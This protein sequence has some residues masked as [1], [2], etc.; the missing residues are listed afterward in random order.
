MNSFQ[1]DIL[2]I[3]PL[4]GWAMNH[5]QS[6]GIVQYPRFPYLF[7]TLIS[8]C[9]LNTKT[10]RQAARARLIQ[11]LCQTYFTKLSENI[12]RTSTR[13]DQ[14]R[15]IDKFLLFLTELFAS[16]K[17]LGR[18]SYREIS[19]QTVCQQTASLYLHPQSK[20]S[21]YLCGISERFSVKLL[22]VN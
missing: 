9:E 12:V 16:S 4:R 19:I 10:S 14:M 20:E 11:F 3:I 1:R 18:T 17:V 22:M 21:S 6:G 7:Y 8:R 2:P 5:S 13:K 15:R